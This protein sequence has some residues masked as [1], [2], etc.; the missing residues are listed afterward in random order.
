MSIMDTKAE[1]NLMKQGKPIIKNKVPESSKDMI[2]KM[3]DIYAKGN[4]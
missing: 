2:S 1:I 4:D 3:R